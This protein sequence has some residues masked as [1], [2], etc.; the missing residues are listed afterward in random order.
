M[1][2]KAIDRLNDWLGLIAAWLFVATG[3]MLTYEVLA[4]YLFNAPTTWA[5]ELSQLLLI[6]GTFLGAA[7]A[8][9]RREHIRITVLQPFMP[10]WL[11]RGLEIF[12]ILFIG[13]F[14]AVVLWYGSEIA[15]DSLTRGRST[16]TMLNL[17]NWWSET[18]IPLSMLL[19]ALQ[20]GSELVKALR[21]S[22]GAPS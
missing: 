22:T 14:A 10:A 8:L 17:P 5:A 18:V 12:S 20:C 6:W 21:R 7:R 3:A 15:W 4:R 11:K 9:Q 2:L 1:P 13:V 19:L 16:G